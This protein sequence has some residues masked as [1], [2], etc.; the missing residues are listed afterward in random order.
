MKITNL[1]ALSGLIALFAVPA[2]A[3]DNQSMQGMQGMSM[4]GSEHMHMMGMHQMPATVTSVDTKTGIVEATSEGMKLRVHFPPASLAGVK[5][6]D[7]IILH[8]GFMKQ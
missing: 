2:L 6:G 8:L 7:K 3:Q 5:A 1:L 4:Q